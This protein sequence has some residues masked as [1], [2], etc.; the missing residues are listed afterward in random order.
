MSNLAKNYNRKKISFNYGKGSYLYSNDGKKYLDFVMG[1]AVNSLGHAHP[2]L[3]KTINNQSKKLW[4]VSNAFQIPEGEILAKKLC[5]KTFADYVMFQNSGAEATEAA[6]KVARRYF[7]SIGKPNKNRI[8]CIKNSFHGRTL[9][10]IYASGSKKM[11]EGF[12]PKV[13]GFDHFIFGDHK[14]LEKKITKDTA[15]IMVET[16]MGEGGIKVIPDF[17]LRELRK[18]CDKK[19]ILLILDEVQCGIGRSGDF[20]AFEKSKVK[21]DIVPIAKGIGGG[22][23]I[24]AVL[25]NKKVAAG[26]VP[27]THGSTFGGNPLAMSVGNKVMD[28]VS[29]K[30]FL[31]NVK[32]LSK[33]F[34]SNLNKIKE[35]YPRIIKQIRGRGFLIGI[36]L[37]Q[38]QTSFIKKLMENKLLTIRAA[39]NV[40][41][42]LPPLNVKKS[43]LDEALKIINKVCG[44]FK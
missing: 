39:E 26:M 5:K 3:V 20:F 37:H 27:G 31:N 6:I 2:S 16:I 15:A 8:L 4:H 29:N 14:A 10:A 36:Q 12:G 13:K 42:V 38:D 19:K 33:Y 1:I 28:I 35:K 32:K 18:L 17:C 25:M 11:T 30:K 43:E 22:F 40:V 21:P 41:R 23:P 9:A 24:G 7:F 44:Q 34:L